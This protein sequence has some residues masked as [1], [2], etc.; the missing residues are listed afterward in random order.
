MTTPVKR[1]PRFADLCLGLKFVA[2]SFFLFFGGSKDRKKLFSPY[3]PR[4]LLGYL[5]SYEVKKC[6]HFGVSWFL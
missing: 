2:K 6:D 3:D 5:K 4:F 1:G